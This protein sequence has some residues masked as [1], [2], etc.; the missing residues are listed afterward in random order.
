MTKLVVVQGLM[1]EKCDTTGMI[2]IAAG[3]EAFQE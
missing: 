1:G 3:P 2:T